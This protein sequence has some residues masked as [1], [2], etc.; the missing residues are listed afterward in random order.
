MIRRSG[1]ARFQTLHRSSGGSSENLVNSA[2]FDGEIEILKWNGGLMPKEAVTVRCWRGNRGRTNLRKVRE[3][4]RYLNGVLAE[5]ARHPLSEFAC[6]ETVWR[7]DNKTS[8]TFLPKATVHK[9][10]QDTIR[11]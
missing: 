9:G 1:S 3:A 8:E 2:T 6:C 7:S 4:A 5:V 11:S 10:D